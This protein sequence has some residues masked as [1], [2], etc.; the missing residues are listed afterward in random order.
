MEPVARI[1]ARDRLVRMLNAYVN[2]NS[3][4]T[5]LDVGCGNGYILREMINLGAKPE[6][7]LGIDLYQSD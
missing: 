2:V 6:N 3:N 1:L 4:L 7:C 5:V